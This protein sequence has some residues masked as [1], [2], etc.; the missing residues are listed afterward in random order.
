MSFVAGVC[1]IVRRLLRPHRADHLADEPRDLERVPGERFLIVPMPSQTRQRDAER[2]RDR[3]AR[4]LDQTLGFFE[5]GLAR[6]PRPRHLRD[7]VEQD[8][9]MPVGEA[10][11]VKGA[12]PRRK[13]LPQVHHDARHAG[14]RQRLAAQLLEQFEHEPRE[15]IGGDQAP[16]QVRVAMHETQGRAVGGAAQ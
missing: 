12:R 2:R 7:R 9:E 11:A 16:V 14:R 8:A 13:A 3:R 6:E 1:V 5:N 10:G 15:R 4:R